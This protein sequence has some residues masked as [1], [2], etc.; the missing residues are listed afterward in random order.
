[1]TVAR[2]LDSLA[3][4]K[5]TPGAGSATAMTGAIAAALAEMIC[6][7]SLRRVTPKTE[8][9]AG[10]ASALETTFKNVAGIRSRLT[11]L[12]EKD[13]T[14]YAAVISA[15]RLPRD[16][17]AQEAVRAR[18]IQSALQDATSPLMEIARETLALFPQLEILARE[19]IAAGQGDVAVGRMLAE[20][21]LRG[22]VLLARANLATIQDST[23]RVTVSQEC[24]A[25]L[26]EAAIYRPKSAPS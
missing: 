16:N 3:S 26:A 20:A 17:P 10:R 6:R 5:A 24:D 22:A 21:A 14:A 1:M 8:G 9:S 2:W 25:L 7:A 19:G 15:Q 11:A 13:A 4:G 12:V 18:A 23:F